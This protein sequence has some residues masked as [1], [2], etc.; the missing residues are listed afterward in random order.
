MVKEKLKGL[1]GWLGLFGAIFLLF[2]IPTNLY[3]FF[4][5]A[6]EN[7]FIGLIFLGLFAYSIFIFVLYVREKKVLLNI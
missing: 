1:E 5:F 6:L 2:V 4:S 3:L 7:L